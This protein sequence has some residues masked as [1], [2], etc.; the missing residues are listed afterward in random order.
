MTQFTDVRL[1]A[2]REISTRLRDRTFRLS[3]AFS[4]LV[5]VAIAILPRVF[6]GDVS[7]WEIGAV[8]SSAQGAAE[9]VVGVAPAEREATVLE[10]ADD[11]AARAAVAD[12]EV[13]VAV[14]A[15]GTLL[16]DEGVNPDLSSALQQSWATQRLTDG[17][18]RLGVPAEDVASMLDVTPAPI[19]LL[20]PPDEER[21]RR[22][23]FVGVGAI[24]MFMQLIGYGVWVAMAI[25]EDKTSQVVEV[26]LAKVPP[27]RLLAG[28]ISGLGVLGVG[29]LAVMIVAGLGA[30]TLADRFPVPPGVW[31]LAIV[32]V[33]AFVLAFALYAA[34]FSISGAIAARVEDVQSASAPFTLLMTGAY[35]GT[36]AALQDPSGVLA[37]WLSFVPFSSP[38]VMPMRL[39][40]GSVAWWEVVIAVVALVITIGVCLMAADRAYRAGALRLRKSV[41]LWRAFRGPERAAGRAA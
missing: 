28:K 21:D 14:L 16:A 12:G 29:Q 8:G 35:I 17:L 41:S 15:G 5:I 13:D 7:T 25:V 30:F 39:A 22:V 34:L 1:I 18:D 27:R 3:T 26:L 11:D 20:D 37:R 2:G 24:L 40:D 31:P 33:I 36:I 32:L 9:R 19:E 4:V 23:G 10:L 6:G 38:L